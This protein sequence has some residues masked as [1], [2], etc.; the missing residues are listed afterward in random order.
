M[1]VNIQSQVFK[2]QRKPRL[3]KICAMCKILFIVFP[4]NNEVRFC[5][6]SCASRFRMLHNN[7]MKI[8]QVAQKLAKLKIQKMC[9][10]CRNVFAVHPSKGGQRFCSK[11]CSAKFQ[12]INLPHKPKGSPL[13]LEE[14][15]RRKSELTK[16][17]WKQGKFANR[18][19]APII[20]AMIKAR[21][22]EHG[23]KIS[24]AVKQRYALD[25][26][27]KYG[28]RASLHLSCSEKTKAKLS[29]ISLRQWQTMTEKQQ[30]EKISKL[31]KG[32]HDKV[33]TMVKII[34]YD[35][36]TFF[37]PNEI[38]CYEFLL[39]MG[40]RR[41]SIIVN[42]P[43]GLKNID[44]FVNNA[45]FWEHHICNA[46]DNLSKEEYFKKRREILDSNG[47]DKYPLIVTISNDEL[48]DDLKTQ[49]LKFIAK[50]K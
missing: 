19:N 6:K 25:T 31:R 34:N 18:N 7:P 21:T 2:Y 43:L 11:S 38:K 46:F 3:E 50:E 32:F 27:R 15:K 47:Y 9:E 30:I 24:K 23:R 28:F 33:G 36:K 10:M 35:E 26:E 8:P 20:Q 5:S 39:S 37:H 49:I 45:F 1:K 16:N 17:A 4:S 29:A 13:T 42:F 41:E 22:P 40:L 12:Q 44:F 48:N 14:R